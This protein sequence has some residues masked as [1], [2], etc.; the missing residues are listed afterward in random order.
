MH[1]PEVIEASLKFC[2]WYVQ[3]PRV[4]AETCKLIELATCY[5]PET[6][7]ILCW[8]VATGAANVMYHPVFYRV[9]QEAIEDVMGR[10]L[11]Q[12][13]MMDGVKAECKDRFSL[14]AYGMVYAGSQRI[15][16]VGQKFKQSIE[17]VQSQKPLERI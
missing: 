3:Q 5:R 8:Q 17:A 14:G 2:I 10:P 1:N 6:N 16:E 9:F 13:A 7:D 4:V 12:E 11:V 15:D